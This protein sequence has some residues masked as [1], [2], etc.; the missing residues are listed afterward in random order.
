[1]TVPDGY[2]LTISDPRQASDEDI[3]AVWRCQEAFRLEFYPEEPA[4][5]LSTMIAATRATPARFGLWRLQITA[6]SGLVVTSTPIFKDWQND[7]NPEVGSLNGGVLAGHRGLGVGAASLAVQ[8]AFH[9]ALGATRLLIHTD[10]RLPRSEELALALG[11]E[12]KSEGHENRLIV[13]DVD[14]ALLERWTTDPVTG[15]YELLFIGGRVPDD[16]AEAFVQLVLVMNTAPRDDLEL[17]DFTYSVDEL[18]EQEA[19]QHKSG[20]RTWILLARHV[21]TGDFVGVHMIMFM[22]HD[23]TKAYV[24]ITG[25]VPE[26]R[27]HRLGRWLKADMMLRLMAEH[28]EINCVVTGNADSNEAML[29]INREMGYRPHAS[30]AT[31]EVSRSHVEKLLEH[32]GVEIPTQLAADAVAEQ[33]PAVSP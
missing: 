14:P 12:R 9:Q 17:N 8:V 1:M 20:G 19:Q 24:G 15:E 7:S 2:A 33:A 16:I 10:S 13:A 23:K 25:V 22:P 18:R 31:W 32:R 5:E 21:S 26:H 29:T 4:A 6:S 27:G 30:D 3:A 11:A 28:P